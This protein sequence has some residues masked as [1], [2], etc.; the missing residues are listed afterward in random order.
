[1]AH[2]KYDMILRRENSD[3]FVNLCNGNSSCVQS[4]ENVLRHRSMYDYYNTG[5]QDI[6]SRNRQ[7]ICLLGATSMGIR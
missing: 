1:M 5:H 4:S 2:L 7:P 3:V 6:L